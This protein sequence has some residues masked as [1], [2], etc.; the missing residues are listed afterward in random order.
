MKR[1]FVLCCFV[2]YGRDPFSYAHGYHR[3]VCT[4]IGSVNGRCVV[5]HLMLD[6]VLYAVQ[7]GNSLG[8]LLVVTLSER[9]VV[10]KDAAGCVSF[11][12]IK[13]SP[14]TCVS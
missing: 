8:S 4:S 9:G 7:K 5:A 12:E 10:L 1:L 3:L 11:V 6:G 2:T 13:K 14:S